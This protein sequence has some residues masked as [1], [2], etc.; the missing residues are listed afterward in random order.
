MKIRYI[1]RNHNVLTMEDTLEPLYTFHNFPIY[2]GSTDQ[3]PEKDI[4]ADLSVAICKKTGIMQLDKVLPLNIV[5]KE[6]HSEALGGLWN[7]HHLTFVDFINSYKPQKVLEIGGSNA[8]IAKE[9]IK[10]NMLI[11]KWVMVEPTPAYGGDDKIKIIAKSFDEDFKYEGQIDT[12]IHSHTLEHIYEPGLFMKHIAQFMNEGNLHLFSVPNLKKYL[13]NNQANWINFEHTAYLTEEYIEYLL[14]LNGFEVL[15]K[16]YFYEHSIFYAAKKRKNSTKKVK[17]NN[18]YQRNK[19]LFN[20]FLT[21]YQSLIAK[22]NQDIF[23]FNGEV[24]LFGA[25]IFSQF[26]ILMGLSGNIAGVLDNS[27]LKEGKRLYGTDLTVFNPKIIKKKKNILVILR[28]GAYQQEVKA[29]LL[30]LNPNVTILE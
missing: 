14:A 30:S 27:N 19:N 28:A 20:N 25:H 7:E 2:I 3:K 9:T 12:L 29:Q 23:E 18:L 1:P 21:F 8:F 16:K 6:Y 5:Y 17:V 22:Y 11:E 4:H 15:E 13:E 24:Y 10:R 26:F